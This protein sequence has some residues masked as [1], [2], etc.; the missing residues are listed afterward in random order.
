M[1]AELQQLAED[2]DRWRTRAS[3]YERDRNQWRE[4]AGNLNARLEEALVAAEAQR[5][6][7]DEAKELA[8]SAAEQF[9]ARLRGEF[10][11]IALERDDL[12]HGRAS[13]SKTLIAGASVPGA[14]SRSRQA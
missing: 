11:Q 1:Q 8:R 5:Q 13:T 7:W 12:P 2:R 10:E 6:A 4:H 9:R 14:L 3:E